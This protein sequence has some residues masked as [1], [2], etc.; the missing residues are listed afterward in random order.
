MLRDAAFRRIDYLRISVTDRCNL[1]CRY[2]MPPAGVPAVAHEDVL[3]FEEIVAFV[4]IAAGEG[5]GA[6]RLTGGEPL[7]RRGCPELV[8]MLRAVEGVREVTLTTNGTLLAAFAGELR[9]A[10]LARVNIGL[11][12]LDA[13]AYRHLTRGGEL[14]DALRGLEAALAHGFAPVKVNVVLLRGLN[15]DP[16]PFVALTERLP[17]EVRFIEYMPI[18]PEDPRRYFVP[19][20]TVLERLLAL[21][22]WEEVE[23]LPGAGPAQRALRRPGSPGRIACITPVSEHFCHGCNRLRLTADGTLR[24]CLL[25]PQEIDLKPALR[26]RPD[27]DALRALLGR[28][29]CEKPRRMADETGELG[30]RMSQIGG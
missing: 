10:G 27:P 25:S 26:P 7:V 23:P 12:S 13:A 14:K 22:P 6:V 20:S 30:R 18:G 1:R 11:P 2:C 24:L 16:T 8:R 5:I 19:A 9:E 29:M 28:A 15:D 3:R 21:G 4:R 17:V